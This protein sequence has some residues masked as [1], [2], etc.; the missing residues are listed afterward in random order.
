MKNEYFFNKMNDMYDSI[1]KDKIKISTPL[2]YINDDYKGIYLFTN[3]LSLDKPLLGEVIRNIC[4]KQS[5][6]GICMI[7]EGWSCDPRKLS[8]IEE[9]GI[10]TGRLK[11]HHLPPD[12]RSTDY[13]I[14]WETRKELRQKSISIDND[15]NIININDWSISPYENLDCNLMSFFS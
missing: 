11:I 15:Y 2:F 4:K 12:K 5:I 3:N 8:K 14:N 1:V 10:K 13:I 6:K 7:S 9:I